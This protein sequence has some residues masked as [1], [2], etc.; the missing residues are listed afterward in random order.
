MD[1]GE[2]DWLDDA[3]ESEDVHPP[4]ERAAWRADDAIRAGD[5]AALRRILAEEGVPAPSLRKP[6]VRTPVGR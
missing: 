5:V 4:W 3:D 6:T 2:G 1:E